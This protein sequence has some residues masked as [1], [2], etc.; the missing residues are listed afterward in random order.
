LSE[1]LDKTANTINAKAK[2]L[3]IFKYLFDFI[4]NHPKINTRLQ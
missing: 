3:F 1:T 2:Y 4:N